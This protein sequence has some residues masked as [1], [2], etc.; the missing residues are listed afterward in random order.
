MSVLLAPA[1]QVRSAPSSEP[2]Y[3]DEAPEPTAASQQLL[4]LKWLTGTP[5]P[6]A[7]DRPRDGPWPG[8]AAARAA[9]VRQ[10]RGLVSPGEAAVRRFLYACLEV[11][12]G[13]RPARHLRPL[14]APAEFTAVATEVAY[15]LQ[16][17]TGGERCDR[18]IPGR[19]G[20][21]G[22]APA[23]VK[24][25]ELLV[26]EPRPGVAEGAAVLGD[27][28]RAWALAIRLEMRPAGWRCTLVRLL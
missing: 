23:R 17:L 27:D 28:R 6:L 15:A 12:N 24:L 16:R 25:R 5:D 20:P 22:P 14:T 2:P 7:R 21:V 9:A 4:P 19:A 8:S 10:T 11:L 1:I 13:Y 3:D 26:C 18:P